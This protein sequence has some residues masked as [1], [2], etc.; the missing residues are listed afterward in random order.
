MATGASGRGRY[1]DMY[2]NITVGDEQP[3]KMYYATADL[4]CLGWGA[5]WNRLFSNDI[6]KIWVRRSGV[7]N[8]KVEGCFT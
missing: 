8:M 3:E 7:K 5:R 2:F 4:S 6:N 1:V